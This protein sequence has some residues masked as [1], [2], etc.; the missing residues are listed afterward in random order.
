MLTTAQQL[1]PNPFAIRTRYAVLRLRTAPSWY[2]PRVTEQTL[3]SRIRARAAELHYD[4]KD[5]DT[6]R[7]LRRQIADELSTRI[8]NVVQA[9]GRADGQGQGG[10]RARTISD[11]HRCPCCQ[12]PYQTQRAREVAKSFMAKLLK[13]TK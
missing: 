7:A 4:A 5:A 11:E 13:R 1:S 12:Q 3:A 9:L 2:G 10:G 8:Q 6:Q